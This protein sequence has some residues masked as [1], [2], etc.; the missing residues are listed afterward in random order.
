MFNLIEL[1]K[2]FSRLCIIF[3]PSYLIKQ[4]SNQLRAC[5]NWI[6]ED[7]SKDK[8]FENIL[9]VCDCLNISKLTLVPFTIN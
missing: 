5:R 2:H 6:Y 3:L 7:L 9:C 8:R 1:K 4:A